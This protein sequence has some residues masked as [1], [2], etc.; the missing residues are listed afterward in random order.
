MTDPLYIILTIL[1][2]DYK[3]IGL[4]FSCLRIPQGHNVISTLWLWSTDEYVF[5]L[6]FE[7][8]STFKST[9]F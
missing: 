3:A 9:Y 5:F 2:Y 6:Y 8:K 7:S 4:I 1:L